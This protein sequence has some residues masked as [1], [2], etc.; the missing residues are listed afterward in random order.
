MKKN[1]YIKKVW[2]LAAASIILCSTA[3]AQLIS[4]SARTVNETACQSTWKY[5]S[6][7]SEETSIVR[8]NMTNHVAYIRQ[9]FNQIG[10]PSPQMLHTFIVKSHNASSE[11]SFTTILGSPCS[12][13]PHGSEIVVNDMRLYEDT[14]YFCGICYKH[15][16]SEN[17]KEGFVAYFVPKEIEAGIST[18][19]KYVVSSTSEL[20]RLA[21]SK[22]YNSPLVISAI[23]K[24][25]STG[26]PCIVELIHENS[27]WKEVIDTIYENYGMTFSDIMTVR[28]SLTLLAQFKCSNDD[29]AG[30][31]NYDFRHQIFLIDRF[32]LSGCSS[33]YNP[34]WIHYMAH[35]LI[36]SSED[37]N[38]HHDQAPMRL[39]HINDR[40]SEFGVAFG[41]EE[42]YGSFGGIRLFQFP[43][44]WNFSKSIYFRTYRHAEIKDLGNMYRTDLLCILSQD[45]L[46]PNG[47]ISV[48]SMGDPSC[49][50]S[51]LTS[52]TYAFNSLTQKYAGDHVDIS[53]HNNN[54]S[55]HLFDQKPSSLSLPSC[56]SV[57]PRQFQHM[58]NWKST[59][60]VV[61]WNFLERGIFDWEKIQITNMNVSPAIICEECD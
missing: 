11:T 23:G 2:L 45:D 32:G 6:N 50:V 9:S 30:S 48:L 17:S 28:D 44:G 8:S 37:Y 43:H 55:F 29:P 56:F 38:F 13:L 25:K 59:Q 47:L 42:Q 26:A 5:Y 1:S 46:Y 16:V 15:K 12:A 58:S 21:I 53:G 57:I 4:D 24:M 41:V 27:G 18:V 31:S 10:Q 3:S 60:L 52:N 20:T 33:S 35:Y 49:S 36:P 7:L 22:D 34:S 39:F 51:W 40:D 54:Y 61:K 14:C 19:F